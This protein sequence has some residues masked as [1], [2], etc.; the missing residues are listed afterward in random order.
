MVGFV[1]AGV[2]AVT[3]QL[4]AQAR[5]ASALSMAVLGITFVLRAI[6]DV[7]GPQSTSVLTWLSPFGWAQATAEWQVTRRVLLLGSMGER[8]AASLAFH[9]EAHPRTMIGIQFAPWSTSGWAMSGSLKPTVLG[10]RSE[11]Q[12]HDRLLVKVHLRDVSSAEIAGDFTDWKP[13]KLEPLHGGWWY[14]MLVVPPGVHRVQL[15]LN[16][17]VWQSPPGLP[18]ADDGPAGPSGT[19]VVLPDT[20]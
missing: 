6:G 15:R 13:V 7:N 2:S 16:G 3:S 17:G 18:R 11:V 19:L 9:S 8:P 5:T 4:T 20:E 12:P 1:F 14:Q 10:W